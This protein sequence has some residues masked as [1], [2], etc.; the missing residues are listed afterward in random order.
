MLYG[1]RLNSHFK[2]EQNK[3]IKKINKPT[4]KYHYHISIIIKIISL[5]TNAIVSQAL[6]MG[7][8]KPQYNTADANI[9]WF[10]KVLFFPPYNWITCY[11]QVLTKINATNLKGDQFS[12][13]TKPLLIKMTQFITKWITAQ[14]MVLPQYIYWAEE[15]S[16]ISV[17]ELNSKEY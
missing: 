5:K 14:S 3:S 7:F 9:W 16:V 11:L 15:Q 10:D 13:T 17:P 4:I 1:D 12:N 6:L 8:T 2:S